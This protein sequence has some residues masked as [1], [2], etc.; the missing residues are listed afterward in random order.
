M[1]LQSGDVVLF[2]LWQKR[3]LNE[4]KRFV[5]SHITINWLSWDVNP[6]N[7]VSKIHNLIH[8]SQFSWDKILVASEKYTLIRE[9]NLLG[10]GLIQG[11]SGV[12]LEEYL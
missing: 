6:D 2:Y 5:W 7:A 9:K 10:S 8:R 1:N 11:Y 12:C 4:I 3:T